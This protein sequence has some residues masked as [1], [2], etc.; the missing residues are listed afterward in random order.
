MTG[1]GLRRKTA[2]ASLRRRTRG[3]RTEP[4]PH[5]SVDPVAIN[6]TTAPPRSTLDVPSGASGSVSGT[7]PTQRGATKVALIT[8]G[9]TLGA[10]VVVGAVALIT[11]NQS[12]PKPAPP[13]TFARIQ[14]TGGLESS[15]TPVPAWRRPV[16]EDPRKETS[17]Q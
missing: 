12:A 10:A 13:T 16:P 14:N 8:G 7:T 1:R 4:L 2:W 15:P 6:P 3:P 5:E 17:L 11:A 9:A